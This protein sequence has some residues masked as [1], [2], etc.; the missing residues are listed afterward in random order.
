MFLTKNQFAHFYNR[1]CCDRRSR[2][3]FRQ[4]ER[5]LTKTGGGKV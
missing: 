5:K 4:R 3:R 2:F 1:Y